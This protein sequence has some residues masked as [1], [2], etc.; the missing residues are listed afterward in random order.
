MLTYEVFERSKKMSIFLFKTEG[1]YG[2][3]T[4][5]FVDFEKAKLHLITFIKKTEG[6]TDA[7][8]E[9]HLPIHSPLDR[10]RGRVRVRV[11]SK[12]EFVPTKEHHYDLDK[13]EMFK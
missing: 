9:E 13:E 11:N 3:D 10:V 1:F 8:I 7:F 4:K 6:K 12:S 2:G 5:V